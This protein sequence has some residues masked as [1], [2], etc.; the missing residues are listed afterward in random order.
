MTRSWP[1][2]VLPCWAAISLISRYTSRGTRMDFQRVR[3][4]FLS[5]LFCCALSATIY[6]AAHR[7]KHFI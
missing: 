2:I 5:C 7:C 4:M 3:S 1:E 6:G